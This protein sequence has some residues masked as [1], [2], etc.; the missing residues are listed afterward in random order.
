MLLWA[1]D[2]PAEGR[3]V[4]TC[5]DSWIMGLSWWWCGEREACSAPT[6]APCPALEFD[7]AWRE[8]VLHHY[9]A[10]M[11]VALDC[12]VLDRGWVATLKLPS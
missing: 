12:E 2:I 6:P 8:D 5:R 1:R 3:H 7:T 11:G 9:P 4:P 10:L